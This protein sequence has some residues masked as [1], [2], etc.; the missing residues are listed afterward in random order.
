V[1][2]LPGKRATGPLSQKSGETLF[3]D[4]PEERGRQPV[5]DGVRLEV[6]EIA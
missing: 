2:L 4:F 1:I 6:P 5:L 3:S